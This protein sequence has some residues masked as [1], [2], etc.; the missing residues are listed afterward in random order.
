MLLRSLLGSW[1]LCR[2]P[3]CRQKAHEWTEREWESQSQALWPFKDILL[4]QDNRNMIAT[5]P[6]GHV[7]LDHRF[8]RTL[9]VRANA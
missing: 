2:S 9:S 1:P 7:G 4:W 3:V 8:G 5:L 6:I